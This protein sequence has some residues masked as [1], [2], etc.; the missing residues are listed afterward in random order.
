MKKERRPPAVQETE[1]R[2]LGWEDPLEKEVATHFRFLAWKSHGQ[3]TLVDY[4]S[5]GLKSRTR[6][7]DRT[8]TP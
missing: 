1:I 7:S 2:S 3:R 5:R 4:S 8:T 6:L